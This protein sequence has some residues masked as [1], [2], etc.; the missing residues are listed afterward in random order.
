M[1]EGMTKTTYGLGQT[2]VLEFVAFINGVVDDPLLGIPL[3]N[4]MGNECH[5]RYSHKQQCFYRYS[6]YCSRMCMTTSCF[7][8][9]AKVISVGFPNCSQHYNTNVHV[10]LEI[11]RGSDDEDEEYDYNHP[12]RHVLFQLSVDGNW[13]DVQMRTYLQNVWL[14]RKSTYTPNVPSIVTEAWIFNNHQSAVHKIASLQFCHLLLALNDSTYEYI[15]DNITLPVNLQNEVGPILDSLGII[16]SL[17]GTVSDE[18]LESVGLS[19]LFGMPFEEELLKESKIVL[20]RECNN[21]FE[22][23]GVT[24]D[25]TKKQWATKHASKTLLFACKDRGQQFAL[26]PRRILYDKTDME[27]TEL[28]TILGSFIVSYLHAPR[29][30]NK[31]DFVNVNC[32]VDSRFLVN[33]RP[34]SVMQDTALEEYEDRETDDEDCSYEDEGQI[35]DSQHLTNLELLMQWIAHEYRLKVVITVNPGGIEEEQ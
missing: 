3:V 29:P 16:I 6:A 31:Q 33:R 7:R 8:T 25:W 18:E 19:D 30:D 4:L 34:I 1:R 17:Q 28:L 20:Y 11:T 14:D 15:P 27:K 12:I 21:H 35:Y 5:V 23:R 24:T 26:E 22:Y 13:S 2:D 9:E 10:V 32:R